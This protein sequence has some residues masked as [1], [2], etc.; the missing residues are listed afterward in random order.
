MFY[1]GR[2]QLLNWTSLLQIPDELISI[3]LCG[4]RVSLLGAEELA[5]LSRMNDI[6]CSLVTLIGP[7]YCEVVVNDVPPRVH[8]FLPSGRNLT[9]VLVS[10][11]SCVSAAPK[12]SLGFD[13]NVDVPH[14]TVV[15]V[16]VL[17]RFCFSC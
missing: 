10:I 8:L 1:T 14:E 13:T 16:E 2:Q 11:Q 9:E 12:G 4:Y 3:R 6:F 7:L 17:T 5:K 15:R